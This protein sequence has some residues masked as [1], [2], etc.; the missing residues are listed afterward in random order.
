MWRAINATSTLAS[1]SRL[2]IRRVDGASHEEAKGL[3]SCHDLALE[4]D[5]DAH[6][7]DIRVR[8]FVWDALVW[9]RR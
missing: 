2:V 1:N 5:K 3:D 6:G 9:W 7:R 8:R 4:I